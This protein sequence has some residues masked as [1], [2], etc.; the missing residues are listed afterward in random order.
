MNSKDFLEMVYSELNNNVKFAEAKNTAI[1]TLNSALIALS[2]AAIFDKDISKSYV[3]VMSIV[4]FFLLFPVI[5][6]LISFRAT[7]YEI[8]R[9]YDKLF[10]LLD[11]KN[12]ILQTPQRVTYYAYIKKFY[13]NDPGIYLAA[14]GE[15]P[16]RLNMYMARQILDLAS[17]CYRKFSLF[18][19]A[20][21]LELI[22]F[23]FARILLMINA[24]CQFF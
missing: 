18:N 6:S 1:I 10:E 17:I 13:K 9:P 23:Y 24:F 2:A 5:C 19:V 20:V 16:T 15:E 4:L 8:R 21:F 7:T 3:A 11:N 14:V 22:V 12:K